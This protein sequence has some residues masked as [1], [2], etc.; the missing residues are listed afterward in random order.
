MFDADKLVWFDF[1]TAAKLNLKADG[2]LAYALHSE[3]SAI[4]LAFADRRR[5]GAHLAC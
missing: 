1:E 2:T 4:V 5:P 3:T